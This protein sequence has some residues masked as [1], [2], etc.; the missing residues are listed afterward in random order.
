MKNLSA[1][2]LAD[3]YKIGHRP[4]YP[5]KT[6]VIYSTWTPRISR[7]DGV[8][9]IVAFGFQGFIRKYLMDFFNENFFKRPCHEVVNEYARV[10]KHTIGEASAFANHI[11]ELHALGF[12]P[13]SIRA[14]PEGSLVPLRCPML[15][16]HNTDERFFWL[17]NFIETLASAE[18]WK[19]ATSATIAKEYKKLFIRM[20]KETGGDLNFVPFQGHD[21]SMRGM[22]GLE[23]AMLSGAG[24]LLSFQGTDSIPSIVYLEN[25][26]GADIEKELVGTSIPAT[27]HSVMCA[28]GFETDDEELAAYKR[29]LTEVYP[30]GFVSVVSDTRDF[31]NVISNVITPLKDIILARNGKLVIRPDSGDPVKIISGDDGNP[32]VLESKGLVEC[33]W[34]IFGGTTNSAGFKELNPKIG[35]IYGEAIN[36]ERAKE[37]LERLKAK[38]FASTNVVFGIGSYT[39]QFNT[40]DTYGFAYKST[41]CKIDGIEKNLFK[42]PKTDDGTKN[43]QK[44]VVVIRKQRQ[45][46]TSGTE[47]VFQDGLNLSD[48]NF[49]GNELREIFRDGK[50]IINDRLSEIRDRL[51][52]GMP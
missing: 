43:S 11:E 19:P 50:L 17:T 35:C 52:K 46:M 3:F 5:E 23:D 4:Q 49:D 47:L 36:L 37:I 24:H 1:M 28:N 48:Q 42:A 32:R 13:L 31:W 18:M 29:L 25:Y 26:Y 27:E 51:A 22:S 8:T 41:H 39:Y 38:G 7:H 6:Q 14:V 33:L 16:I 40:R 15:T 45:A 12:L 21:F 10:I 2:L 9:E 44:G 20:A 34:D 30:E